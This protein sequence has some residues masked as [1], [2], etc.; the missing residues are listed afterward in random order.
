MSN[1]IRSLGLSECVNL[2]MIPCDQEPEMPWF[3]QDFIVGRSIR[4]TLDIGSAVRVRDL[5]V[6]GD[7]TV[8][9]TNLNRASQRS[10]LIARNVFVAGTLVCSHVDLA[11]DSRYNTSSP[12]AFR[13]EVAERLI[14][15]TN[16]KTLFEERIKPLL[17]ETLKEKKNQKLPLNE[18]L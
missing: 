17:E 4:A 18:V 15:L 6:L 7:L 8:R 5:I 16:I 3:N 2:Y 9:P 1:L 14:E 11:Y 10:T 13:R 12:I